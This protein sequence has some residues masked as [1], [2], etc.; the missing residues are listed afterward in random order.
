MGQSQR[1]FER[2]FKT[3]TGDTPV[4]YLQRVRVEAAKR[5]LEQTLE[6][7]EQIT[8]RVG[9]EDPASFRR[10]FHRQTGLSPSAYRQRF[11]SP[12]S[13]PA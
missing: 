10:V 1:T 5:L 4:R 8:F 7:F 9:Y 6:T 12:I 13:V 2:R 11:A 3:A